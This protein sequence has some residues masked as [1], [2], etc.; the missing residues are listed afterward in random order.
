MK[1]E[2]KPGEKKRTATEGLL[3]LMRYVHRG[4]S[5]TRRGLEFTAAALRRSIDNTDEELGES[6]SKAYEQTLR[7]YHSFVV[8]PVFTVRKH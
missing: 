2:G 3:W 6:F 7:Q 1:N 4:A 8:R 5:L